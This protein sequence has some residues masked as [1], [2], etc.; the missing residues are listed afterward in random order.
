MLKTITDVGYLGFAA[1]YNNRLDELEAAGVAD[2]IIDNDPLLISYE[3]KMNNLLKLADQLD[4]LDDQGIW[5]SFVNYYKAEFMAD[6][7][8]YD[9]EDHMT[10]G[11]LNGATYD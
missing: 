4:N 5:Q 9:I 6:I 1:Q 2:E 7:N 11:E 3:S 10:M 8:D